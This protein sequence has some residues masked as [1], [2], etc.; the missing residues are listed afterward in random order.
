[1]SI[2]NKILIGFIF[3]GLAAL[4][5]LAART[6]QTHKYW[7]NLARGY[8]YFLEVRQEFSNACIDGGELVM[9]KTEAGEQWEEDQELG[10]LL[11]TG[12][13]DLETLEKRKEKLEETPGIK[14]L[15]LELHK[16]LIDRG[17]V[18][19]NCNPEDVTADQ[20]NQTVQVRVSTALPD[21]HG[22]ADKTILYVFEETD[23]RQKGQ[24]LGRFTVTG[25]DDQQVVLQPS[26]K[27]VDLNSREIQLLAASK[28]PWVLYER[29][30]ADNHDVFAGMDEA[31]LTEL[32]KGLNCLTEYIKD[33][34]P[35]TWEKMEEWGVKG[36]L[37]DDK[38][39][40]L[41]D[42]DG[43]KIAG[44]QGKYVRRLRD[45]EVLFADYYMQRDALAEL[46]KA[47]TRDNQYAQA[48]ADDVAKQL[49]FRKDEET[50]LQAELTEVE[51][52]R[53]AAD[54]LRK[55]LETEV[56][57]R[58]AQIL[59]VLAQNQARAAEIARNQVAAKRL[60][61]ER[62]RRMARTGAGRD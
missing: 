56:D 14:R 13:I 7:R 59:Q 57:A 48:A 39:N 34:Q 50:R 58:K 33:G 53:D 20:Q 47:A 19:S 61:D 46:I 29:M 28:G 35:A 21:P 6:L 31:E 12:E 36:T 4:F 37:V 42:E 25:V 9:V 45:Y 5:Y 2:W 16:T 32:L 3:L 22:I 15:R 38:G 11:R 51:R 55:E 43:N 23:V 8:G 44:A 27:K 17:R 52:E 24:Y 30:P 40:A 10:S 49:Q 60:I 18:W 41:V 1:M 26:K 62:T 54:E